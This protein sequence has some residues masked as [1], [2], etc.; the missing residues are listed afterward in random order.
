MLKNTLQKD[1]TALGQYYQLK[2]PLE[3][4]VLIPANEPVRLLSAFVENLSLSDLYSTYRRIRKNQASPRQLLK[5]ILYSYMEGIYSSRRMEKA[6][7]SNIYFMYL[8]EGMPA[9][10]HSTFDRFIRLHFAP[11]AKRILACMEAW[12]LSLGEI[13]GRHLFVDGTKI[14]SCAGRYT[15]VW[16]NAVT[17]HLQK[18]M[19]K[20]VVLVAD[21]EDQYDLHLAHNNTVSIRVLK[22]L[23]KKLYAIKEQQDIVFVHGSGKRK[24]PLQRSIETLENILSKFKDYTNKLHI[25]GERGSYAKTDQDATFMRMKEDH[26]RNGQLKPAYN[27]QHGV[28]A[29]YILWVDV[30]QRPTDARTLIPFLESAEKHLPFQY[31]EIVADA[32]YESEENYRYLKEHDQLAYIKPNNYEIAKT[33]KYK[34]DIG[35]AENMRYDK[36]NDC[37]YCSQGKPLVHLYDKTEKTSSGYRRNVSVYESHNCKDCP[38]KAA[39]I[40]PCGSKKPMEE[41]NKRLYVS[42]QMKVLRTENEARITGEYGKQLRM[43]RS[44]Q[45]EGSFAMIKEDMNFRRYLYSGIENVTAQSILLAIA[46]NVTKL[47]N[48]IQN[49]TTGKYL[50]ELK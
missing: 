43:N 21:L 3:L 16:K 7:R 48:K 32:G 24:T 46:Y 13:S 22:K 15:F 36:D 39:C 5:I 6:C 26:M 37:Y 45:A 30:N 1:Y 50:F 28:D 34:N 42:K 10:D 8:L 49:G 12:L 35:R 2:L 33:R 17:K 11:C 25:C 38:S 19:D 31:K 44:I 47:H 4:D 18:L 41:R 27:V 9:P 23:R 29:E 40:R 20:A 14:E